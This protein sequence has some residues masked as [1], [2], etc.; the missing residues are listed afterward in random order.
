MAMAETYDRNRKRL[1]GN[2][3]LKTQFVS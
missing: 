3:F 1:R 2:G